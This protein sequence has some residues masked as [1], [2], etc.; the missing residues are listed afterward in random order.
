[1][2]LQDLAEAETVDSSRPP[3]DVALDVVIAGS[4]HV[5]FK[6][7]TAR[8]DEWLGSPATD[9]RATGVSLEA[10]LGGRFVEQRGDTGGQI[11]A[12]VTGLEAVSQLTVMNEGFPAAAG[13]AA[14]AGGRSS[15]S[16][17]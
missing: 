17:A 7:I 5:V 2:R 14:S 9:A 3:V 16:K 11:I 15:G 6:S 1:L 12:T 13:V 4:R 10:G 8:I